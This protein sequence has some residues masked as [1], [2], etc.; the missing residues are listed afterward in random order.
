[1]DGVFYKT[2]ENS[3]GGTGAG[4]DASGNW[5]Y[6]G[7]M[8]TS[9]ASLSIDPTTKQF[10]G[11]TARSRTVTNSNPSGIVDQVSA[12]STVMYFVGEVGTNTPAFLNNIR[13]KIDRSTTVDGF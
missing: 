6:N 9:G 3:I 2:V 10:F 13:A 11:I 4:Q 12:L 7:T 5:Y 1:M 8:G